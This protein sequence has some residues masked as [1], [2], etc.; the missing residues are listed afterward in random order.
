M[1][2]IEVVSAVITRMNSRGQ[3]EILLAKRKPEQDYGGLWE[4]PGGKVEPNEGLRGA[5]IRECQEELG[6]TVRVDEA[7]AHLTCTSHKGLKFR[8]YYFSCFT[9]GTP[10]A[11]ASE[12]IEWFDKEGFEALI[13]GK[14]LIL[15][16]R[17]LSTWLKE[18]LWP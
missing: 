2:T 15:S 7:L 18:Y 12:K 3:N 16:G 9:D 11:L 5:L 6:V 10:Q 13:S 14:R 8:I 17:L 1:G 4:C